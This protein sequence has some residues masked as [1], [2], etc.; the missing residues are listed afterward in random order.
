MRLFLLLLL[1]FLCA[2]SVYGAGYTENDCGPASVGWSTDWNVTFEYFESEEDATAYCLGKDTSIGI[3]YPGGSD[4]PCA[5]NPG[6]FFCWDNDWSTSTQYF[7]AF[8]T[9]NPPCDLDQATQE[10]VSACGDIEF[11]DWTSLETCDW[12]CK[13]DDCEDEYQ[14][15]KQECETPFLLDRL[16]CEYICECE[17]NRRTAEEYCTA[18]FYFDR[19]TCEWDCKCCGDKFRE[20][21]QYCRGDKNVKPFSCSDSTSIASSCVVDVSKLS[22]CECIVPPIKDK[23]PDPEEPPEPPSCADFEA[24]CSDKGCK[25]SC[26]SDPETG[27]ILSTNCDCGTDPTD[28]GPDGEIGTPDD[29]EK[30]DLANGWLKAIEENTDKTANA[31]KEAGEKTNTWLKA[32]KHNIDNSLENDKK[33]FLD[34]SGKPYLKSI[35]EKLDKL[36]EGSGEPEELTITTVG[37]GTLPDDNVYSTT[38]TEEEGFAPLPEDTFSQE[39][40]DYIAS[41][42]PLISYIKESSINL[43][44]AS[45]VL[46][47]NI[48]GRSYSVDFSRYAGL[49]DSAGNILLALTVISSFMI[50]IGRGKG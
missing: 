15:A 43:S 1:F 47:L 6:Y 29:E 5:T 10:A 42:I 16:T 8:C 12:E 46:S 23:E 9:L 24:A 27:E 45:S 41:G 49:V 17:E 33:Y 22:P 25:P 36:V 35:S 18:G 37:S 28:P 11:V 13:Q 34:S 7:G 32:I 21:S 14:A 38:F 19:D 3:C 39:L 4:A 48:Y 26:I 2:S 20:C 44:S 30:D 31:V 50:I 40:S